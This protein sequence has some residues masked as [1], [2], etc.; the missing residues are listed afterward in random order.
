MMPPVPPG[1]LALALGALWAAAA[2]SGVDAAGRDPSAKIPAADGH[3]FT[4]LPAAYT[5]VRFENRLTDTPDFNVFTYRNFYNGGGVATADLTGDGLPEVV[6]TSNQGGPRLYLNEG[7]F[8]FR[9]ITKEAGIKFKGPGSWATGVAIIDVN[10]D[11]WPDLYVSN[12]FF[13][14]DYLYINNRNG[15]FTESID[16]AAPSISYASMGLDVADVDNDGRPDV[17]T[18]D[19]LPEDQVRLQTTT[20]WDS[21]AR[22]LTNV[23]SGYH[24]QFTRNMLQVNNGDGTFSDVGQMAGVARTD[25]SWGAL[26][27]DFDMDG[28]KDIFV[29]NGIA[30]DLTSQDYLAWLTEQR[31]SQGGSGKQADYLKLIA[32]ASSTK[33]PNYAFHN[34]GNLTFT[35]L[36]AAWGLS[37]PSFSS[38][39]AYAD[40]DG[41]GAL[42]LIVNNVNDTAFVYRNNARTLTPNRYL[43]V[44][45][46]GDAPNRFAVGAKVTLFTGSTLL[47]QELSPTRGFQSSVDYVLTFGLGARDTVDSMIVAWPGRGPRDARV[48]VLR[49]V[50][51]NHRITVREAEAVP[52]PAPG[53][54]H[55]LVA[56][57]TRDVAIPFVHREN[58]F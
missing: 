7:K 17:Y 34:N 56:D 38:G 16:R 36:S 22:Y 42:D 45:L 18:T 49:S 27:A 21:W 51:A 41:D 33:L 12:D 37:T 11:G 26:I 43:Q 9:D 40:L 3:L 46:D 14:K 28:Q 2:C 5:G 31:S 47:F 44:K 1:R 15:T 55:R 4:R 54:T 53:L 29:T 32:A 39:A 48:S 58:E 52:A 19:M 23:K 24:H 10:G 13:E 8:H 35:N 57:V 6:L 25:W 30:K 20:T 50:A